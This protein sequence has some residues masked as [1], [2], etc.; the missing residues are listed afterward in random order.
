MCVRQLEQKSALWWWCEDLEVHCGTVCGT[1]GIN[2]VDDDGTSALFFAAQEGYPEVV[3]ILL[4]KAADSNLCDS[5]GAGPLL[6]AVQE[7]KRQRSQ[8]TTH[9]VQTIG[10]N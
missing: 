10:K 7:G 9:S 1:L 4:N 5:H 6:V 3:K 8:I 2:A